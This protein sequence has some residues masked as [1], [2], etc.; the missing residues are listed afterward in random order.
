MR[1]RKVLLAETD[2]LIG[3]FE[4]Q[5]HLL[6]IGA[7]SI[8]VA[9]PIEGLLGRLCLVPEVFALVL[10]KLKRLERQTLRLV[11]LKKFLVLHLILVWQA[12][13][14]WHLRVPKRFLLHW[15]VVLGSRTLIILEA[16]GFFVLDG[17]GFLGRQ[18]LI[19]THLVTRHII[20]Y[21]CNA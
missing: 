17:E 14:P 20:S 15:G 21:T 3:I 18:S 6:T 12:Q 8:G 16:L 7:I 13:L 10:R 5:T 9:V 4:S 19:L 2:I 11:S 1:P